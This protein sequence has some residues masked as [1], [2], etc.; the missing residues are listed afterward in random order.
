MATAQLLEMDE[1]DALA[2]RARLVQMV[3]TSALVWAGDAGRNGMSTNSM[4]AYLYE[5]DD[6]GAHETS[7]R[8]I[9]KPDPVEIDQADMVHE[10]FAM[11]RGR[12]RRQN[13]LH[14]WE[15]ALLELRAWQERGVGHRGWRKLA[16]SM[17]ALKSCPT[18]SYVKWRQ[19]HARII[20]LAH[21]QAKKFGHLHKI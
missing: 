6:W 17:N 10:W 16:E 1:D 2:L 14:K 15:W 8:V 5:R 18:Y 7:D 4:P 3:H 19:E 20:D 13:G 21:S 12:D 11:W 9:F